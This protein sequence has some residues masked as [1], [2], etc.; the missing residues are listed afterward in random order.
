L[1]YL[2]DMQADLHFFKYLS[3]ALGDTEARHLLQN[4]TLKHPETSV[5]TNPAKTSGLEILSGASGIVPWNASG[6]YLDARPRFTFDPALHQGL[7]YVQDASSMFVGHVAAAIVEMTGE[8]PINVLDACAA[9]GGKTTAVVDMLPDGSTVVANEFDRLRANILT[10]NIA[11]WGN[12]S[13]IVTQGDTARFRKL[14]ETFD[15]II[16]DA[17]CSGEGMMR[18][19]PKAVEQWSPALV[20]QCAGRQ[21]EILDNLISCIALGGFLVYSTCTFNRIENEE[22][23]SWIISNHDF[24]P[25]DISID[26]SWGIHTSDVNGVTCHRFLPSRLRGEGLFLAVMRRDG[27]FQPR[28]MKKNIKEKNIQEISEWAPSLISKKY[29]DTI[30][31]LPVSALHLLKEL[32]NKSVNIIAPGVEIA[33]VKGRDFIPS[34]PLALSTALNRKVFHEVELTHDQALAFLR[35]ETVSL[36]DGTPK[37]HILLTHHDIPVGFVKNLGNRANNLYPANWRIRS[38]NY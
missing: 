24:N 33:A 35:R 34:A 1:D 3:Q 15:I 32:E 7:Y 29:G 10:E 20:E 14:R 26:P 6:H 4:I 13:V 19:D 12:P 23:I 9:P 8:N 2:N 38:G 16:V 17:P 36:P 31:G 11:K 18:K 27:E 22:I 21:R 28:Q 25:V 30:F 5:R 37:G